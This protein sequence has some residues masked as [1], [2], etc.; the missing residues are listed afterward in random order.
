MSRPDATSAQDLQR[1]TRALAASEENF[2]MLVE[3]VRDYAIFLLDPTGIIT[4]W[5]PG[6]ER[7]KRYSAAEIIGR[8]FSIFYPEED[9]RSGK[10]ARELEIAAAA[11]KYEEEGWRLRKDGSRFWAS[12]LI[13][14]LKDEE[15]K[16]RG[17]AKVTRDVTE[18]RRFQEAVLNLINRLASEHDPALLASHVCAVTRDILRGTAA[19][20]GLLGEDGESL[21]HF[22]TSGLPDEL[23]RALT[24]L[25]PKAGLL[26]E[27]LRDRKPRRLRDPAGGAEPFGTTGNGW[28]VR[29]LLAVPVTSPTQVHGWLFVVNKTD[30]DE[31]SL[32][33]EHLAVTLAAQVAVSYENVLRYERLERQAADLRREVAERKRAEEEVRRQREWLQVTLSSIGDAVIA[34]DT[35]GHVLFM[36]PVAEQLTGWREAEAAGGPLTHVFR[37]LNEETRQAVQ[38]PVA[39]VLKHGVRQ[40]LANHTILVAKDGSERPIDDCA[41]PI[42]DGAGTRGVVLIFHDVTERRRLEAQLRDRADRLVEAD[43]RKTQFLA[44]LAHELRNPLG[45]IR[46][47]LHVLRLSGGDAQVR[48]QVRDMMERQV[49]HMARMIDDLLD[50]SRLTRGKVSLALERLDLARL[51]RLCA[52]DHRGV[53]TSGGVTLDASV[54]AAPVWVAG[55]FA[56]LT[57]VF[58]NLL[59]NARK[60]TPRGGRVSLRLTADAKRAEVVVADTGVGIAAEELSYL[61]EPFSQGE[62]S[63]DRSSGG[64]GLGLAV[65]RGLVELHGGSIAAHSEG[66]GRGAAFVVRLPLQTEPAALSQPAAEGPAR[67]AGRG[68]I[69]VIEDNSD[70][71]ESL[72]MLLRLEGYEVRVAHDGPAGLTAARETGPDA[73]V[74]DI[75]LP[76]MDGFKVAAA[77]RQDPATSGVRLIA[78]TGYGQAED[79]QRALASGFDAH[80]IKPVDPGKLLQAIGEAG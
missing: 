71:A 75:G 13:T 36:N 18:R 31:F 21:R 50:V 2:R 15:G 3:G 78:L 40:G 74:C 53:L 25:G 20:V 79:R 65:A 59:D 42:R 46:N 9:V 27:L 17:F 8:H 49:R 33:D 80:L 11:G 52:E 70:A 64:L 62:Q 56:R 66:Q 63:L 61:F 34:T 73:I 29:S 30:A 76:G 38:C 77:L 72:E 54:P 1:A 48:D 44:M 28:G 6:A 60:F 7:I 58:G 68:R 32:D 19:A 35:D 41:A 4:T 12:V 51:L 22:A 45:P 55:D 16:L 5:N 37:I 14:A 57:Q 39:L 24:R 26:G 67:A 23:T 69:L 47:G 10:P 43:R